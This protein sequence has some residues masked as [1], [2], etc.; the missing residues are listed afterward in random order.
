MTDDIT[1][2]N[3]RNARATALLAGAVAF[4]A[5]LWAA[6]KPIPPL[7]Y[8]PDDLTEFA[9]HPSPAINIWWAAAHMDEARLHMANGNTAEANKALDAAEVN[10]RA[11]WRDLLTNGWEAAAKP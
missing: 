1:R 10:L 5:A 9:K 4:A 6:D 3:R 2:S 8:E 7:D 11:A